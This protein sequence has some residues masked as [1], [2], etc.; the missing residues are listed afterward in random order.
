MP[1]YFRHFR[2]KTLMT[3]LLRSNDVFH[4]ERPF[5]TSKKDVK[6]VLSTKRHF[7]SERLESVVKWGMNVWK[8]SECVYS[9][10]VFFKMTNV[11]FLRRIF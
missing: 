10:S 3:D 1:S 9:F 2:L 8:Q 5:L 11:L 6:V 7:L 4:M